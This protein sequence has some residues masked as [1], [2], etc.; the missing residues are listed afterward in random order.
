MHKIIEPVTWQSFNGFRL[1]VVEKTTLTSSKMRDF[2]D[3][4]NV[5]SGDVRQTALSS[6]ETKVRQNKWFEKR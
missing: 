4:E 1:Q 6:F 2:R 5:I 3:F